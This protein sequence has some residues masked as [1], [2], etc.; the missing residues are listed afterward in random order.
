MKV[1]EF[2][3]LGRT[4]G[5]LDFVDVDT[6]NDIRAYVDPSAIRYLQ[7]DWGMECMRMLTTF[8]DSVLDSVKMGD[9]HRTS[10]LLSRLSE[11]NETH[12]GISRGKSAGRGFGK[13]MGQEFAEKLAESEA[14]RTGLIEDLEDTAFFIGGV[15]KD[16]VSDVTTNIIRGPLITYT[17]Q[18]ATMFDIPLEDG[19]DSGP[20]WNPETLEWEHDF[21]SLPMPDGEKLLL[22]PKAIV[23]RSMHMS[24]GEYYRHH[25]APVLQSEVA[26]GA[27]RGLLDTVR[28]GK[29][30][31]AYPTKLEIQKMFGSTKPDITRETLKRPV[32]YENYRNLKK[33]IRPNTLTHNDMADLSEAPIPDFNALLKTILDIPTGLDNATAYHKATEALL[34]AL[35][36]PHLIM[37]EMEEELHSGRKRVD[38][39]YTNNAKD[40]FFNFLVRHKIPAKYIFIECK[41]YGADVK[42]PELDQLSG[43]FSPLRGKFGILA[44]RKFQDKRLFLQRCRDTALDRRGF[45][46]PLDDEDL[47]TLV[48]DVVHAMD[49][50]PSDPPPEEPEVPPNSADFP[51]LHERLK[52]LHS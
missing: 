30:A 24:R 13:Q 2:Y 34:T 45:I 4:Q 11:P 42:N 3:S 39:S 31:A 44:C 47:A 36:Y 23:R 27:A 14:A 29:R 22:V 19:V 16:I 33:K 9:K 7:D 5:S 49:W 21:T 41:N 25:L 1:S 51:L 28:A 46:V 6:V 17:Q 35:F 10:D 37:P 20:V 32:I 15:D 8:F 52:Y 26:G 50:K 38:I 43:R 12:L 18:M 48:G 40:G